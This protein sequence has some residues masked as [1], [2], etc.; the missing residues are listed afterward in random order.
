MGLCL[1]YY[2]IVY[3][4][5]EDV[6]FGYFVLKDCQVVSDGCWW[7]EGMLLWEIVDCVGLKIVIMFW[8]GIEVDIY[9]CYFDYWW[10]YDGVVIFDQCVDQ[11][12]VWLDLLFGQWLSF[13][14]LYFDVVDYVGYDFGLDLLQVNQVLCEIDEVLGWLV[15]GLKQCG[16]FD[17]INIIVLVDYG[18]V[19]VLVG[20]VIVFDDL[21]LLDQVDL[22]IVGVFVGIDLKFGYVYVFVVIEVC[23]E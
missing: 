23:M 6:Q 14:M 8:F 18:M 4:M 19:M 2:G 1:D 3:N 11:L 13:F 21:L 12:F 10:F 15:V 22:V 7:V 17:C 9:G 20:Y 16:L 5:M